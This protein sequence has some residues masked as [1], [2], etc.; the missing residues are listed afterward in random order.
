MGVWV[1][2]PAFADTAQVR[3]IRISEAGG[4]TAVVISSSARPT[5]TTWKL[6]Q[7]ARVVVDV[8]AARLGNVEVPMDAGTYA[9]GLVSANVSEEEGGGSRTRIVL[10]LRQASDYRVEA[11][12]N[13]I[14]VRVI[15]HLHPA[16]SKV[17]VP[18]PHDAEV[19]AEARIKAERA[20][21]QAKAETQ[22]RA[23]A[24]AKAER[25]EAQAERAEAQVKAE[26][27]AKTEART[28]QKKSRGAGRKG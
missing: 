12:G 17:A 3:A 9:V 23:E 2:T 13:D 15:P 26:A 25:A 20:E 22:A 18:D 6:E 21:A 4:D 16:A 14:V 11:R 5:F 24:Q 19:K 10:T 27:Q 7:P 28:K 1:S 8:S